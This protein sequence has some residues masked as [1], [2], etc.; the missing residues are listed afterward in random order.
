MWTTGSTTAS[1]RV[2][3]STFITSVR[4][5]STSVSAAILA[6]RAWSSSSTERMTS[7]MSKR[8][9]EVSAES[10]STSPIR[11]LSSP[12]SLVASLLPSCWRPLMRSDA[13]RA[14]VVE[15]RVHL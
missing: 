10:L 7:S 14:L 5:T 15:E 4:S 12:S 3:L 2:E 9:S 11:L 8:C 6:P 1:T 13:S